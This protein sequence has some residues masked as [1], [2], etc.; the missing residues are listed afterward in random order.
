MQA[1]VRML[2]RSVSFR[3]TECQWGDLKIAHDVGGDET[4]RM[5]AAEISRCGV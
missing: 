5:H 1:G 3:N 4:G 2:Y